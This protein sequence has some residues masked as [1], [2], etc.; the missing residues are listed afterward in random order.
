M[1]IDSLPELIKSIIYD[2]YLVVRLLF[3]LYL[4]QVLICSDS[5]GVHSSVSEGSNCIELG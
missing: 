1:Y 5:R 4:F 2:R 3:G